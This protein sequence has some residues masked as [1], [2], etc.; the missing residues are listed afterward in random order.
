MKVY[1]AVID[2]NVI[3][4][5][6][7]HHGSIPGQVVDLC[8]KGIIVPLLNGEILNEYHE[9][10]SRNKFGIPEKDVFLFLATFRKSGLFLKR[11]QTLENFVDE[12]DIVFFEIALSGRSSLE[13]F[14]VTGNLKHYPIRS[15]V[16]TPRQMLDIIAKDGQDPIQT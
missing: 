5:S 13:A 8:L 3:V 11:T 10:L 1:Y 2:T 14:L 16:V 6:F 9:V 12:D 7:L 15:Y 4:S